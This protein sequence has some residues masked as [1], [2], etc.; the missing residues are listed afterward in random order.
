[1]KERGRLIR[2]AATAVVGLVISSIVSAN[3]TMLTTLAGQRATTAARVAAVLSV[4]PERLT[5]AAVTFLPAVLK[6]VEQASVMK[7]QDQP[8]PTE[9]PKPDTQVTKETTK[10]TTVWYVN[11]IWIGLIVLAAIALIFLI[12]MVLRAGGTSDRTTVIRS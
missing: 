6:S 2:Y 8:P 3:S 4:T 10:E 11:P 9:P 1:M 7:I 5:A 12:A